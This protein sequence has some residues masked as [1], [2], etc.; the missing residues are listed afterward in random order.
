MATIVVK[1]TETFNGLVLVN[2]SNEIVL[3]PSQQITLWNY[4]SKR[5]YVDGIGW[6][7]CD[8]LELTPEQIESIVNT[9]GGQAKTKDNVRNWLKHPYKIDGFG[10][11]VERIVLERDGNFAYI[12]MQD[13]ISETAQFRKAINKR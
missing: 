12:A 9:I 6:T 3:S 13:H 7:A 5:L 4:I 10:W 11:F 8:S 1:N 2:G